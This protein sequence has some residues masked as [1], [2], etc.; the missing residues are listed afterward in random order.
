[1]RTKQAAILA[2]GLGT[3]LRPLTHKI[4]KPMI[5]IHGK[6]FLEYQLK[7]LKKEGIKKVV[8]LTGYLHE[9]IRSYFGDYF[10]GIKL[11]YSIEQKQLGTAGALKK[12]E[13]LLEQT[14]FVLNGDTYFPLKLHRLESFFLKKPNAIGA[15]SAYSGRSRVA[16]YNL[17]IEK[18]GL[19]LAYS[20]NSPST[21]FNSVD[22]GASIFKKELLSF[23]THTPCSLEDE[24]YPK[25][26]HD[27]L[28]YAIKTSLRF[29][30]IGTFK[31]LDMAKKF[32]KRSVM[33]RD[34][35]NSSP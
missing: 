1:M 15:L 28:L 3:R 9:Q 4:P 5:E 10:E 29:Y 23:I 21:N 14:F 35:F 31:R 24:I 13:K 11:T 32:F 18:S 16:T 19:V 25:L 6:P 20:K 8:L 26:I 7:Y 22:A 27:G 2:G 12:A 17:L 30:D 34:N 33:E